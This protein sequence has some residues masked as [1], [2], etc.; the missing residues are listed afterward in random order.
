MDTMDSKLSE[1]FA[2]G[3]FTTTTSPRKTRRADAPRLREAL[4][5]REWREALRAR[6]WRE[7]RRERREARRWAGERRG[8]VLFR[9]V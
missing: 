1:D 6:E 7:V 3:R 5:A 2:T 4:R 8:M 9:H